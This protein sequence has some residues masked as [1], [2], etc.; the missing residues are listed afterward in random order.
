MRVIQSPIYN[1]EPALVEPIHP[2]RTTTIFEI[3]KLYLIDK[4]TDENIEAYIL[5][6]G[7]YS[8]SGYELG[9]WDNLEYHGFYTTIDEAENYIGLK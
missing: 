1:E 3:W 7:D 6:S 8:I 2:K 9:D 4:T 5:I